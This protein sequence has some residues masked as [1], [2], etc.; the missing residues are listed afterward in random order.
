MSHRIVSGAP[1]EEYIPSNTISLASSVVFL[2]SPS[3]TSNELHVHLLHSSAGGI[4]RCII[5]ERHR[6]A[7]GKAVSETGSNLT[8]TTKLLLLFLL[9]SFL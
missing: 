4:E 8:F 9:S 6:D 3:H 1:E 7:L 2:K 5:N